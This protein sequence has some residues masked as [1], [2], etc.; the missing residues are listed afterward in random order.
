[1]KNLF[2]K[3][4]PDDLAKAMKVMAAENGWKIKDLVIAALQAYLQAGRGK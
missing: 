3:G 4:L 1:M 2:I